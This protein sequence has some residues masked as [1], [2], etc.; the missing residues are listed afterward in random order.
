MYAQLAT[1]TVNKG[2]KI[3]AKQF[4]GTVGKAGTATGAHLHFE[5]MVDGEYVDPAEYI[6]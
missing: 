3:T 6:K 1:T 2:D 5:V 4:S